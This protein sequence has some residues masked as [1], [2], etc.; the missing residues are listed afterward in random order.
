ME[1]YCSGTARIRHKD[2]GA[3]YDIESDKLAWDAVGGG[4][5]QMGPETHYEAVLEHP[6]LGKLTWGLW[7]YPI[8]AKNYN[9]TD[10]GDHKVL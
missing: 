3:V 5:R 10:V 9:R 8:G 6:E 7:E 4:E 1:V 2:T